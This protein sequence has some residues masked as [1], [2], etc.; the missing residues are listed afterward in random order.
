MISTHTGRLIDPFNPT[1]ANIHIDDIAHA[2]SLICRFGG[3]TDR[4]YSVAEHC[5]FVATI[6][7]ER[8]GPRTALWG[9]LHD[10]AEAYLG[11][12][13]SPLKRTD[14]FAGYRLAEYRFECE[15]WRRYLQIERDGFEGIGIRREIAQID[16]E[17]LRLEA[18][19]LM[20]AAI[21]AHPHS[22]WSFVLDQPVD[23]ATRRRF[24]VW[25]NPAYGSINMASMRDHYRALFR[26][27]SE[28]VRL[29]PQEAA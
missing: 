25:T 5:I 28:A 8:H 17:T 3:Q 1:R 22:H 11:D 16:H 29:L 10:A 20:P 12:I 19:H 6:A 27:L 4:F 24:R 7:E 2:L 15:I 23:E 21:A 18:E 14:A 9:L 13:V 26:R